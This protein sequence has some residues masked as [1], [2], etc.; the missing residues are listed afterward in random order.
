MNSYLAPVLYYSEVLICGWPTVVE[1]QLDRFIP[2]NVTLC[3]IKIV[4]CRSRNH[5]ELNLILRGT[6]ATTA[7]EI[8][9]AQSTEAILSNAGIYV[10][11][12]YFHIATK[13]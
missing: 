6:I 5:S 2:A 12:V 1:I 4:P 10:I 9:L 13:H 3:R 8:H 7:E 11:Y